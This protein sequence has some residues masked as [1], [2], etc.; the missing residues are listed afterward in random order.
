VVLVSAVSVVAAGIGLAVAPSAAGDPLSR[1]RALAAVVI[2]LAAPG[3]PAAD[4]TA[5]AQVVDQTFP[6]TAP[7]LGFPVPKAALVDLSVPAHPQMGPKKLR[8]HD[9]VHFTLRSKKARDM[10]GV[11]PSLYRGVFYDASLEPVRQCI[12]HRES[13][14]HYFSTN[15]SS[16]YFGGYQMSPELSAGVTWMMA[17]EH[18]ELMGKKKAKRVLERLRGKLAHKWTRYW[19]DAAFFTI[20]NWTGRG[21]GKQHWFLAGSRCV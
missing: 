2:D 5:W 8:Q 15:R 16:G 1:G 11:A 18:K 20:Y 9:Y 4:V 12:L 17:S 19:Q 10:K 6:A 21:S 7:R 3:D 13:N 14:G